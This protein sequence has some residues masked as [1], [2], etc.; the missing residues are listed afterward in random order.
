M[1]SVSKPEKE[2][3]VASDKKPKSSKP[4]TDLKKKSKTV[5]KSK[6]SSSKKQKSPKKPKIGHISSARIRT[7]CIKNLGKDY[8]QFPKDTMVF[9]AGALDFYNKFQALRLLSKVGKENHTDVN[10][11]IVKPILSFSEL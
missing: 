2:K 3:S 9:F 5:T 4:E 6:D 10:A 8:Y 11:E 7:R 1:P